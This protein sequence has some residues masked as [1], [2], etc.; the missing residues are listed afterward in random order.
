[1]LGTDIVVNG[2][3]LMFIVLGLVQFIKEALKLKGAQVKVVSMLVGTVFGVAYQASVSPIVGFAS[4]FGVVVF[5][6]AMGL[7]AS[8]VY[9]VANKPS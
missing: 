3:S 1:M 9:D 4:W 2:V 7:A 5:S 8:G 6:V